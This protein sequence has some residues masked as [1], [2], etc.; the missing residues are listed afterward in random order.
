MIL[1]GAH[2]WLS[3]THLL[4]LDACSCSSG[5]SFQ[6][7]EKFGFCLN[8]FLAL[9]L[10]AIGI[11]TMLRRLGEMRD[12]WLNLNGGVEFSAENALLRVLGAA[13]CTS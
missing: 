1:A 6:L 2:L 10:L 7:A 3:Q 9:F 13:V 12:K 5:I 4:A 11:T 8:S